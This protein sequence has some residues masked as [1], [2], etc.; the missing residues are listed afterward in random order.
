MATGKQIEET[1]NEKGER[2]KQHRSV[3]HSI[4]Q[5]GSECIKIQANRRPNQGYQNCKNCETAETEY[6][7][8][9]ETS[10]SRAEKS[11]MIL[12]A[13]KGKATADKGKA[14]ADKGKATA[15]KEKSTADKG[16][17][18]IAEKEKE[19]KCVMI[20]PADKG[21]AAVVMDENE[22]KVTTVLSDGKT[23]EKLK[24][25]PKCGWHNGAAEVHRHNYIF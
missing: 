3:R 12:T 13:D 25:K 10:A 5:V 18:N 19:R 6:Q 23:Y 9:R 2:R 1:N 20:L 8:E 15:D 21:K 17:A 16:K 22:Q 7:Q 24:K 14:T 11:I 4:K